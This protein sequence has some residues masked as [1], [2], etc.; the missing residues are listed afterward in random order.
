MENQLI[1]KY[2]LSR[3]RYY[4]RISLWAS[5]IAAICNQN[6]YQTSRNVMDKILFKLGLSSHEPMTLEKE[7]EISLEKV[8]PDVS[9]QISDIMIKPIKT[10]KSFSDQI[11]NLDKVLEKVDSEP[12]KTH[13]KES[14]TRKSRCDYGTNNESRAI[15]IYEKKRGCQVCFKGS[16]FHRPL[17]N[18][19]ALSG[20]L[21]GFSSDGILIE[22]KTRS[23]GFKTPIPDYELYQIQSYL[24]ILNLDRA[25]L[26]EYFNGKLRIHR[27]SKNSRIR[28]DILKSVKQFSR[29]LVL[30]F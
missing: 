13:L 26:L 25:D 4:D 5:D 7:I 17:N 19:I 20:R 21:D 11:Q 12:V 27:I 18:L 6:Q 22:V 8:D 2:G 14:L 9:K 1:E 23:N 29:D 15:L 30:K 3:Q 10:Q 28:K 16:Y 24:Y